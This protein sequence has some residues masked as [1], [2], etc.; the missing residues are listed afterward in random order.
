MS[1]KG[2]PA[3][4]FEVRELLP[5]DRPELAQRLIRSWGSTVVVAHGTRY[6][7]ADLP[8]LLAVPTDDTADPLGLLT[9]HAE[10]DTWEIVTLDSYRERIGVGGALLAEVEH[11][12]AAAGARQLRLVTTNDNTHALRFYQRRGFELVALRLDAVDEARTTKPEIPHAADGISIRHELEL[13][14]R[15][16]PPVRRH[17]P[18]T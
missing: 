3:S 4:G 12:A 9:Y 13:V 16:D 11:R 8:G 7:A 5:S 18:P 6:D 14:K 15:L 2:L 17:R 10:P 1:E